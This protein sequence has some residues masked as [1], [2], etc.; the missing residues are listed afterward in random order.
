M[1]APPAVRQTPPYPE[2]DL[3]SRVGNCVCV[4][5][6]GGWGRGGKCWN[7]S[8]RENEK[9]TSEEEEVWD[10]MS[11]WRRSCGIG[12]QLRSDFYTKD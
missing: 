6:G 7:L 4:R 10:Q 11:G 2:P 1:I 5:G 3:N 8:L 9:Q 12:L